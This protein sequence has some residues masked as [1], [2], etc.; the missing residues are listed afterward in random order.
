MRNY[1]DMIEGKAN[2]ANL[3]VSLLLTSVRVI[4]KGGT[5]IL[6]TFIVKH[7]TGGR[8]VPQNWGQHFLHCV[9]A[10]GMWYKAPRQ[11]A[12]AQRKGLSQV[13]SS[14]SCLD[15]HLLVEFWHIWQQMFPKISCKKVF[16]QILL[17]FSVKRFSEHNFFS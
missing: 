7:N 14:G 16:V 12:L 17:R 15:S 11:E 2:E 13:K 10:S 3:V 6:R 9:S 5:N 1:H 4:H 8:A